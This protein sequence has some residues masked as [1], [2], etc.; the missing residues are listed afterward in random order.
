MQQK[1]LSN[2]FI[3]HG[4]ANMKSLLPLG[5]FADIDFWKD[6]YVLRT[7][8]VACLSSWKWVLEA[9]K[10]VTCATEFEAFRNKYDNG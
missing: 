6:R 9:F 8:Q 4:P 7:N 10:G 2:T 1:N 3:D 5:I